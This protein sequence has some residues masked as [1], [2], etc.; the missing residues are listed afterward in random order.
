MSGVWQRE[1]VERRQ[2]RKGSW[3]NAETKWADNVTVAHGPFDCL[4]TPGLRV[5]CLVSATE[6]LSFVCES[7]QLRKRCS[8]K[9]ID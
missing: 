3:E 7:G 4:R 8:V 2:L 6:A 5:L 1:V 9:A